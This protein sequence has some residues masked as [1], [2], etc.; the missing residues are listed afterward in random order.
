M[1]RPAGRTQ[2]IRAPGHSTLR[3]DKLQEMEKW[4]F[5]LPQHLGKAFVCVCSRPQS[6]MQ[7]EG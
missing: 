2:A 1:A 3:L 5:F 6:I 4:D 7:V